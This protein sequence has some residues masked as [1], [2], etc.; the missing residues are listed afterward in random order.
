MVYSSVKK[1]SYVKNQNIFISG[2]QITNREY[3]M[4]NKKN[5]MNKIKSFNFSF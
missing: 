5:T 2:F 3:K 4:G 1:N